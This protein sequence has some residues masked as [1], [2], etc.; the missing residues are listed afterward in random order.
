MVPGGKVLTEM[1]PLADWAEPPISTAHTI[2]LPSS[3]R[4]TFLRS[5]FMGA[6]KICKWFASGFT[7]VTT[8][9]NV[10]V[11]SASKIENE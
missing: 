2:G 3:P 11:T 9:V 4:S 5:S 1:P 6:K 7:R 8:P 10:L